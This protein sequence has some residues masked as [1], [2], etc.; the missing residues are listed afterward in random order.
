MQ[1]KLSIKFN[2]IYDKNSPKVGIEGTYFNI[3]KAIYNNKPIANLSLN[4]EKLKAFPLR[5]TIRK[6]CPVTTII[7]HS[8]GSPSH[9]NQRGK[10]RNKSNPDWKR[11]KIYL[12]MT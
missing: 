9:G 1:R 10:K 7:P 8:F 3:L 2:T 4:G 5:S 6:E 12:H 11:S